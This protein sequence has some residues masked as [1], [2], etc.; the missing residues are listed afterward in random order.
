[1]DAITTIGKA[2][3]DLIPDFIRSDASLEAK[4]IDVVGS[5]ADAEAVE[6]E[7]TLTVIGR[8]IAR[9]KTTSVE[10]YRLIAANFQMGDTLVHDPVNQGGMYAEENEERRI[11]KQANIVGAFPY[12][13]LLVNAI[14]HDR[15]L[16]VLGTHE[17]A[18]FRT[19]FA[20]FQPLGL[21]I[22]ITSL[23]PTLITDDG[24][25]IYTQRGADALDV[26]TQVQEFFIEN[27]AALQRGNVI[28]LTAIA[29]VIKRHPAVLAVGFG[30]PVATETRLDGSTV[31]TRPSA[32]LFNVLSGAYTFATTLTTNN[33]ARHV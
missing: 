26:I 8:S 16:R 5:Y 13:T 32:G 27:E 6:R 12:Y 4:I 3:Q 28:S 9:Q 25:K 33:V 23:P 11:I 30:D 14:G 17:L 22:N 1:M 31:A 18:A 20:A 10:Y 19:Y 2:L 7:N 15:H 29:E 21:N 24:L